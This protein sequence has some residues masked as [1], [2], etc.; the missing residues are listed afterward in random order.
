MKAFV[1][2]LK[3]NPE[4][5][6]FM[7]EQLERLGIDYEF[8]DAMVG[9]EYCSDPRWYDAEGAMRLEGRHLKPGEV[10]C[11]LSHAAV[12][13]EIVRR[14]LPWALVIEDDAMLHKDLPAVLERLQG[15]ELRQD[16]IVFLERCDHVRPFSGRP[17]CG[18]YR[19]GR[20][21]FVRA[22]STAQS[23]GYVVTQ[24][25]AQALRSVNVPVRFPADS[26]GHY[27]GHVGFRGIQP[28]LTLVRQGSLFE[29]GTSG[30]GRRHEFRRYSLAQ[31]LVHDLLFYTTIGRLLQLSLRRLLGRAA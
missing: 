25:A 28:T 29:S 18:R 20:P 19:I 9:S 1:I 13:A 31:L 5:R 30:K 4:R 2:N 10:G 24:G 15:G 16:E 3:S 21:I 22:G 11:A 14:G 27:L 26:W 23:A 7:K 6:A 8:F 12:Y 17:L